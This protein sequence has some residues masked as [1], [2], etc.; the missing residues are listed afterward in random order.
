MTAHFFC[1]V[2]A[3][4]DRA[5]LLSR[6]S[7]NIDELTAIDTHVHIEPAVRNTPADEAARKYFKETEPAPT[8]TELADYYRSRRIACVVFSVDEDLTGRRQV[9]NEDVLVVAQQN[10]D[11][12]IPFASVNPARGQQAILQAES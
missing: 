12:M 3:V 4:Y 7:M 10:A 9:P 6:G 11:I 8:I 5:L 1:A 2:G